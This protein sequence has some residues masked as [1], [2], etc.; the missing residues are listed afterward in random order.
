MQQDRRHYV[1]ECFCSL[2]LY[3]VNVTR[4][5]RTLIEDLLDTKKY[6][7]RVRPVL[8]SEDAVL[9]KFGLVIREIEDLVSGLILAVRIVFRT[10]MGI[11]FYHRK[12]H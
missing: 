9:I 3:A 8:K 6:N 11:C 2:D 4:Q 5:K 1:V 12:R 10:D 7:R